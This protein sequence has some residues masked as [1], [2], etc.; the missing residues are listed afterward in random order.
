M[1]RNC[2]FGAVAKCRIP[3]FKWDSYGVYVNEPLVSPFRGFG[4]AQVIFAVESHMDMAAEKLGISPVAI[5]RKNILREG[6]TNANGEIVHSI[7]V[8]QCLDKVLEAIKIDEKP[9]SE[10]VWIRGKGFAIGNKYSLAPS[11]SSARIKVSEEGDLIVYHGSTEMGQGCDTVMAQIAA[12]EFGISVD[13]IRVAYSEARTCRM[14]RAP[15]RAAPLI[16]RERR[17]TGLPGCQAADLCTSRAAVGCT[18]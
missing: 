13:R 9:R 8:S 6:E 15:C 1:T 5:R 10:G 16:I 7:G 12:E 14:T 3:N 17:K 11:A 4:N 2:S 18:T